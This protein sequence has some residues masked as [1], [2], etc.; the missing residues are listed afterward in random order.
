MGKGETVRKRMSKNKRTLKGKGLHRRT[1]GLHR[2][3]AVLKGGYRYRKKTKTVGKG[4]R[5]SIRRKNNRSRSRKMHGGNMA[6]LNPADFDTSSTNNILSGFPYPDGG[7][8]IN[9]SGGYGFDGETGEYVPV[10]Q[11]GGE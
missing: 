1:K 10:S 4:L 6:S 5:L 9:T 2:R 7:Q 8:S 11:C 3:T